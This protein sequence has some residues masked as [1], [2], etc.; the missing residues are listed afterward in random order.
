[1]GI[2]ESSGILRYVW[3]VEHPENIHLELSKFTT[4]VILLE[5]FLDVSLGT[6]AT[7][8]HVN[9][10]VESSPGILNSG[11]DAIVRTEFVSHDDNTLAGGA[12]SHIVELDNRNEKKVMNGRRSNS[13]S[14]ALGLG[15]MVFGEG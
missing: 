9:S 12:P 5:T 7:S 14:S 13:L 2:D 1:M 15:W 4:D 8:H 3:V 11:I 10:G 6:R